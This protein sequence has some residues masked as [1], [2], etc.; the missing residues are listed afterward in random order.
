MIGIG[1]SADDLCLCY[2]DFFRYCIY[3]HVSFPC[4]SCRLIHYGFR[5]GLTVAIVLG[6]RNG[7]TTLPYFA[8]VPKGFHGR[9]VF[10]GPSESRDTVVC[11]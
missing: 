11:A 3:C 10:I 9:K 2:I 1:R 5:L 8:R 7:F 6:K 4:N